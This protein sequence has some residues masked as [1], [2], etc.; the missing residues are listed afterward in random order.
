MIR[1]VLTVFRRYAMVHFKSPARLMDIF[2]WPVME[3]FLWGFF[4]VYLRQQLL[5][6]AGHFVLILIN[7]LVFWDILFRSQQALSLAFMEELWTKNVLNLFIAPLSLWE[8]VLGAYFYGIVKT[9]IIVLTLLLLATGLYAFHV[10]AL[11]FYL[12]PLALNLLL[13][14][15]SM[16]LLTTGLLL[17]WGHAAEALIWAG[18]WPASTGPT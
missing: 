7:A 16:G 10:S 1:R 5:D 4:S 17:R 11:G 13:F 14:G 2:F 18:R 3:L 15:Y 9:G 6:P 12:I 8:W